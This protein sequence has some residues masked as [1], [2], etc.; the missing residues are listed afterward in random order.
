MANPNA[1]ATTSTH[2]LATAAGCQALY[3]AK[4]R[5]LKREDFPA[6]TE[7]WQMWC[8]H[9]IRKHTTEANVANENV[10]YWTKVRAGEHIQQ[11]VKAIGDLEKLTKELEAK[12]AELAALQAKK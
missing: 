2:E 4:N 11:A 7:G 8:D 10:A 3:K 1:N 6:T 12:K 5:N 9:R